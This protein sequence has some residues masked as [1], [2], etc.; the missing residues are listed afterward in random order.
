MK[1]LKWYNGFR[2]LCYGLKRSFN[3]RERA[4]RAEYAWIFL[5]SRILVSPIWFF[6]KQPKTFAFILPEP[7]VG[8]TVLLH[9]IYHVLLIPEISVS[10][11]RLHDLGHSGFWL[12]PIYI[13]WLAMG[14][15]DDSTEMDGPLAYLMK[16]IFFDL[17]LMSVI[18]SK[19][20]L[21]FYLFF[22]NGKRID[23]KYG[24]NP[25]RI[26]SNK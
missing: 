21:S 10:V 13:P 19:I 18:C 2:W 20:A 8:F 16:S 1:E 26:L 7:N 3:W 12:I 25:K 24:V 23:N 4:T 22:K 17:F 6:A 11:R 14:F 9:V 15:L 5:V